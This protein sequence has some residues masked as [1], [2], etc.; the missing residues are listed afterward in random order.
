MKIEHI[1]LIL[2]VIII[3]FQLIQYF[4]LDDYK[5][6]LLTQQNEKLQSQIE[7]LQ[8][9]IDS[10]DLNITVT[11][12]TISI[13]RNFYNEKEKEIYIINDSNELSDSIRAVMQRLVRA[14]FD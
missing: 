3:I 14:R 1:I 7:E 2:L 6:E 11:D 5:E 9:A 4:T 13:T 8:D 12:T 10:L